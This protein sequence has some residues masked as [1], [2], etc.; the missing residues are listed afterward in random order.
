M[1]ECEGMEIELCTYESSSR[2]IEKIFKD[3]RKG[4]CKWLESF[5]K[6]KKVTQLEILCSGCACRCLETL[7]FALSTS[8]DI[9]I[10]DQLSDLI[11]DCWSELVVNQNASHFI[12][13]FT[14]HLIGLPKLD[15][16]NSKTTAL[17]RNPDLK[18]SSNLDEMSSI[19]PSEWLHDEKALRKQFNQFNSTV[20]LKTIFTK[21]INLALDYNLMK[22]CINREAVSLLMQ[23]L[24]EYDWFARTSKTTEMI[25]KCLGDSEGSVLLQ[26]QGK[27]SSRVWEVLVKRTSEDARQS[28]YSSVLNGKLLELSLHS[29][30]NFVVGAFISS[31]KSEELI[32]DVFD[33]LVNNLD[34]I[35]EGEKWS[36]LKGLIKASSRYPEYQAALLKNLRSQFGSAQ[37]STRNA[38]LPNILTL[39]N[40]EMS[41]DE[42]GKVKFNVENGTLHGSLMLQNLITLKHNKTLLF[43]FLSLSDETILQ[44]TYNPKGS[45]VIQ[46][47]LQSKHIDDTNKL[48]LANLLIVS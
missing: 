13:S 38:F 29:F 33:E 1:E 12:R 11:V 36:V 43:S 16:S 20:G 44:M 19:L 14:R 17:V 27:Q 31:A 41:E 42:T 23:E 3:S 2:L 40:A 21:I 34:Q 25:L 22:D 10:I 35:C 9:Q 24:I 45:R 5:M 47:F 8:S 6:I 18:H 30:A 28:L 39:N 46:A 37:K 48:Q 15:L 7:L 26:W 4:A 32:I